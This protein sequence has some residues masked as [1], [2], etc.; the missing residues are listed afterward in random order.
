M[1]PH[2][3]AKAKGLYSQLCRTQVIDPKLREAPTYFVFGNHDRQPDAD[4]VGGRSYTDE[5]LAATIKGNGITMLVDEY[6]VVSDDLVLLGRED[7]SRGDDRQP[8]SALTSQNPDASAFLLVADHQP[9]TDEEDAAA[10]HADLQI[11]GHT[12]AGQLFPLQFV[13]NMVGLPAYG[14]HTLGGNHL[15]VSSGQSG[16]GFPLRTEARCT[17]NLVTL[18]PC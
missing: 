1:L 2:V 11:S 3:A 6:V 5:E 7:M 16:W 15:F 4:L 12:H 13:Y 9:Y 8:G 10:I 18:S 14:E 17:W